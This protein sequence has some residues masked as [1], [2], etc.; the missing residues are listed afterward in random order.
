[1]LNSRGLQLSPTKSAILAFSRKSM[2]CYP[3]VIDGNVI[4]SVTHHKFLGVIIDRDLSW[5]KHISALRKKLDSFVHVIRHISGKSWGPSKSS[6][7]QLYQALF[8]GYLRY[9]APVLS[10]VCTSAVRTLESAQA[11][12]LRICLGVPRC[13]STW[14]TITE[15]R[16]CPAR[17]YLK[18]E[19]LRVHLRL[20]TRHRDHPLR[21]IINRRPNAAYSEAVM[22]QQD[23]LPSN[24]APQATPGRF[25]IAHRTSSTAAELTGV[26]Q[27]A[28]YI[29]QQSPAKWTL[30][31]DSK[32]A[33]QLISNYMKQGT[34]Y[35][36]LVCD[37]MNMLSE[38]SQ[39]GHTVALQWIPSHC[40]IAGNE[41]HRL[42][43]GVAYTRRYL[44][45]IGQERNPNCSV[46][47]T[48]ETIHH[49]LCVCPQYATERQSL[50]CV[51]DRLDSRPF[52][53][54]KL[55]GAWEH[56]DQAQRSLKCLLRFLSDTGLDA[57]L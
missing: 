17:V 3:V 32:P 45:K 31:C 12:A 44:C 28:R 9:S 51:V 30:F 55:L 54:E 41:Q 49:I 7:L 29:V 13:T 27:A 2:A 34:A 20:L 38:A 39:S 15:A 24:Y 16:A 4:P 11:R 50:K 40:G 52:S 35:S 48:S 23:L 5:S 46:C 56:A 53:E 22:S 18:H 26:R 14:G 21:D 42:R 43:L 37:I 19:P 6:L 1:Y 47:H 8:V 33:L 25:K 36:P 57:R 10:R